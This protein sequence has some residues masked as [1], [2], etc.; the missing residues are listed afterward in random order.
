M[1]NKRKVYNKGGMRKLLIVGNWKMHI[2]GYAVATPYKTPLRGFLSP[3]AKW[4]TFC[5][6][7]FRRNAL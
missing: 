5:R 4:N 7:I 1:Y 6:G 2:S 3:P